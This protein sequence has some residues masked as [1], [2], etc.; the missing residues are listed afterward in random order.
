MVG[1]L[2]IISYNCQSL[3]SNAGIV[4][5]LL[6]DCDVL[7]LQETLIDDNN[8]EILEQMD[9]D[10]MCAYVPSVRKEGCYIGRSA[11]GL[12]IYY[13]K[14]LNLK[15]SPV[16]YDKRIMGL[17]IILPDGSIFLLLNVY[18]ICD[19]LNPDCYLE[20]NTTLAQI[21]DILESEEF[22]DVCITGDFN[23]DPAK[24]RFF[25]CLTQFLNGNSLYLTDVIN[26]PSG[27]YTYIA[28]N[29]TCSTSWLDHV[30]VSSCDIISDHNI[31]Y[32]TT[33]FD[34]IPLSFSLKL[35]HLHHQ[36]ASKAKGGCTES[37]I[38][39]DAVN[40]QTRQV[41]SDTLDN[42]CIEMTHDVLLCRN[43]V[44][45]DTSHR[46]DLE[47]LY[48]GLIQAIK[49]SSN[50]LPSTNVRRH[51]NT[52]I[53]WNTHCKG[54]YKLA[55]EKFLI[56]HNGGRIRSGD[57][58]EAMKS[59][60]SAFKNALKHCKD[61]EKRIKHEILLT[62]FGNANKTQF[63]KEISKINSTGNSNTIQI[64]SETSAENTVKIFDDKYRRILD[65]SSCQA[66]FDN[67]INIPTGSSVPSITLD[68]VCNAIHSLN[69]GLGW[70]GIHANHL[71]FAGPVFINLLGKFINMLLKHSYVPTSMLY[72][73]IRPVIK[74]K[75]L[76]KGDS[77]NYR[78]VL[79]SSMFLK[80]LEYCL[81]P[82][83][84][85]SLKLSN[86]QFGYR[87]D[88]SCLS[89]I[90]VVKETILKYNAEKSNVHCAS[91]DLSKAFDKINHNT[92]FEKLS[93]STLN[94]QVIELLRAMYD[95]AY[96]HTKFNGVKGVPWKIGNG[97]RQ[98]GI[99]SPFLFSYYIDETLN[100]ISEMKMGCSILGH[101]TSVVAYAD[102]VI[103][104]APSV[105]SIQQMFDKL[106]DMFSQLGMS[107]N[108]GKSKYIIFE[109]RG[110]K[111]TA[112]APNIYMN[113]RKLGRETRV[114]YLGVI[115]ANDGSM[116]DDV[117]RVT[118]SFL[119]QFNGMYWR[120][121]F[122]RRDILYFLFKSYT[123]SFYGIDLWFETMPASYL[124]RV[125]I[126]YHKAVKRITGRHVWDSNHEACEIA[127]VKTFRHL[128]ATRLACFWHKL[129]NSISPCLANLKYYFRYRSQLFMK[130]KALF[131]KDYSVD[132]L[133]NPLCAVKARI[134]YVQRNEPRSHYAQS[135]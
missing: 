133:G 70:D 76:G 51:K 20:Y 38:R 127:G 35:P 13:R 106:C 115:L 111:L 101:K 134:D 47:S 88:T 55:R 25:S 89:A 60:R 114:T 65:D 118:N 72:G 61:N 92:L 93:R 33:Q 30:C 74:S 63:W 2:K 84:F 112:E 29:S 95:N 79:N 78:P 7:C 57:D 126:A 9:D 110:S 6:K 96:V 104:L 15:F 129:C 73:E 130:L 128:R 31:L 27:S 99:L 117:N 5:N 3:R 80:V 23:A 40:Q 21:T 16:N 48:F 17:K 69:V 52:V 41:Y 75:V 1:N 77:D 46:G 94:P 108:L 64:D 53:G 10:F 44:C 37:K 45:N 24:G 28:P 98:G 26:L 107:I 71:K 120:Y 86:H 87:K 85:N 123:S 131:M 102:D 58:F 103:L 68:D 49:T 22:F 90:A 67:L 105:S 132:I 113:G 116:L 19:Y 43:D 91:I 50:C 121:N 81:Q 82:I 34:H 97:V 119:K 66:S 62:K 135:I 59:S 36:G 122:L 56:W 18:M 42:I 109:K 125:C 14:G 8:N 83:L 32:G 4:Q 124:N 39:W 12:V 11:G 100:S 54:Y